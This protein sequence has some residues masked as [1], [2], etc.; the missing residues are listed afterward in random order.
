MAS[1]LNQWDKAL[2]EGKLMEVA[3]AVLMKK[4]LGINVTPNNLENVKAVDNTCTFVSDLKFLRSPYPSQ[5]TPA[6][7]DREEHLTLDVANIDKYSDDTLLAM[8]VDYT[9]SGVDTEGFYLIP[10]REVRAIMER[11]PKRVYTRSARTSKDKSVK[12][13]ISINEAA[14]IRFGGMSGKETGEAFVKMAEALRDR[15]KLMKG[16]AA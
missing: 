1:E 7:L 9:E 16:N 11:D 2:S 6:G 10:V 3:F 4:H 13:G 8:V 12:V 5:K 14:Q 15:N